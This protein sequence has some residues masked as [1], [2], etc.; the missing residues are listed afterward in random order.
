LAGMD[1][2]AVIDREA[3]ERAELMNQLDEGDDD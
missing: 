2:Q 1:G 3:A